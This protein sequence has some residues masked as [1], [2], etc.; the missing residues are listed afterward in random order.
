VAGDY[1]VTLTVSYDG[2]S[3]QKSVTVN[4]ADRARLVA[5][6][7]SP[8]DL[9]SG[10]TPSVQV[11]LVDSFVPK[12]VSVQTARWLLASDFGGITV[13][14]GGTAS[15]LIGRAAS[16]SPP[17]DGL[18]PNAVTMSIGTSSVTFDVLANL[19]PVSNGFDSCLGIAQNEP[20]HFF[21]GWN[22][23]DVSTLVVTL[24]VGTL[25]L[26]MD[27]SDGGGAHA[28][29][30]FLDVPRASLPNVAT[31]TVEAVDEFGA[32][33]EIVSAPRGQCW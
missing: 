12:G 18:N 19:P 9:R 24:H 1:T 27:F 20:V 2:A 16:T 23:A 14:P 8:V 6:T 7:S 11:K 28:P 13:P 25:A 32:A 3:D 33:S 15:F 29:F 5:V 17:I 26:R 30:N 22:D 31:W 21:A 10:T 4:V